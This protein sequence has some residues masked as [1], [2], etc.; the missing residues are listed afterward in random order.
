MKRHPYG[1]NV[2]G[3]TPQSISV[4]PIDEAQNTSSPGVVEAMHRQVTAERS[5]RAMFYSS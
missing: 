4:T 1:T 5:K 2:Y 3:P